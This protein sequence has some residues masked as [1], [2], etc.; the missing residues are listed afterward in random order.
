MNRIEKY[1]DSLSEDEARRLLLK[2]RI[3]QMRPIF[4]LWMDDYKLKHLEVD[5]L[6]AVDPVTTAHCYAK[7]GDSDSY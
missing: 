2:Y 1:V 7:G 5:S 3:E 4:E 6:F